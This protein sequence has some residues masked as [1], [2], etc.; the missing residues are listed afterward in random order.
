MGQEQISLLAEVVLI[1]YTL[2][3][4]CV[5]SFKNPSCSLPKDD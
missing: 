2:L 5:E 3:K 1:N 4:S